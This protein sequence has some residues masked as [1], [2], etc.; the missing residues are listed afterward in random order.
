LQ[1]KLAYLISQYPTIGHTYL[2]RE[3][4]AL[5]AL[6]WD[7][8][9]V[10]VRQPDRTPEAMLP[11]ERE[12]WRQTFFVL[13][14]THSALLK[15]NIAVF[16][17]NPVKYVRSLLGAVRLGGFDLKKCLRMIWYF[18]EA[19]RAGRW[20]MSQS[21]THF[22]SHFSSTPGFLITTLFPLT[23]SMTVHGPEEF[24]NPA[25]FFLA[26]K[27]E[28]CKFVCAI[29]CFSRSQMAQLVPWEQWRKFEVVPLGIDP[30]VFEPAPF[31]ENPDPFEIVCV[32]RL[33]PFK[34]QHVLLESIQRL[35]LEGR[36]VRLR[37]IG[38]GPDRGSLER[39]IQETGL[40]GQVI[41]E[42]WKNQTEVRELYRKADIFALASSAEG[43]P[44]VLMEA[45][46]M[47][48]PCV[49]TRITGVPELIRDGIDGLLVTPSDPVELA[50]AIARLMDD[51][52][53]RR[54]LALA[55]R[56]RVKQKYHLAT[57]AALLSDVFRAR[58]MS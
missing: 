50:D 1:P 2:L 24:V 31:R 58:L 14:A 54:R 51:S 57:N 47:E 39:R 4:R 15:D 53:L 37:F 20:M 29:S 34:A 23:M 48:L 43:V 27:I 12:E 10:S 5:R 49:A 30:A 35:L 3:L 18:A 28:A 45:M 40:A 19:A 8:P 36:R 11:E 32:G 42:G 44:V 26:R 22:H 16:L 38:D 6:G 13:Q 7:I 9:T 21:V 46:A 41:L 25:G 33:T 52:E 56:E 17:G 55:G